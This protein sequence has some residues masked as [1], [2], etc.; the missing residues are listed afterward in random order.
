MRNSK[1][2]IYDGSFNGFLSA[3]YK[4]FDERIQVADI[5]KNSI[6][7][8]GLFSDTETVF[9]QMDQ[10]KRVWNG[11]QKKSNAAI[12]NIYFA[13]LSEATGIELL[14]YRYIRKLYFPKDMLQLNFTDDAAIRINQLAKSVG[15]EKKYMEAGLKFDATEDNIQLAFINP[16]NDVLPLISK[17]YRFQYSNKPWLIFDRKRNYGLYYN[18]KTVEL[19]SLDTDAIPANMKVHE[20]NIKSL[21]VRTLHRQPM[22]KQRTGYIQERAAV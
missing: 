9:T 19:I 16:D 20:L 22:Q 2:L 6:A 1:I 21:L 4:A 12:K 18:L 11:V 17:H 14:L 8:R 10:A 3:V 15:K 7:Q 5:Q 13:F